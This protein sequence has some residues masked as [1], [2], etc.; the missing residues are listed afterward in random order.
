[1]NGLATDMARRIVSAKGE[2][3]IYNS[4]F[5]PFVDYHD[6]IDEL[7]QRY[8]EIEV[9]GPVNKGEFLLRRRNFTTYT[10]NY[11]VDFAKHT[12]I[13]DIFDQIR[14]GNPTQQ[15]FENNGIVLGLDVSFSLIATVGDTVEVVSPLMMIP[16]PFG[17]MPRVEKYRVVGVFSTG[18]PEFDRLYS[19]IDIERSKTLR[20]HGGVDYIELKTNIRDFNY[21]KLIAEIERDYPGIRAEHW[22]IFDKSLFQAIQI[23]KIALFVVMA[24]I[25]VLA[26]F[27]ITGNFVR[28][29]S[30]K[31][32]EIALL[33]TLGLPP[34]HITSLF[35]WMGVFLC[36]GGI[37]IANISAV[38]LIF[39]QDR[40][41]IVEIPVPGFPFTAVPVD[42][43]MKN[44]FLY[45]LLTLSICVI[46]I[47][48]PAYKTIKINIIHILNEEKNK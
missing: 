30:Q 28:T 6:F 47:I 14:I 16:T 1:M 32:E 31:K 21:N 22:E 44:V 38:S 5:S 43:N 17:L 25:I 36:L 7:T 3:R 45:S 8:E 18:L 10:E 23:E 29:V 11:G 4:D 15:S 40:Y 12:A 33:K 9:A 13:S 2:I 19:F 26:S 42:L 41:Q 20:R 37:L 27:N 35:I 48:Y 34:K 24:I 46:G 39:I